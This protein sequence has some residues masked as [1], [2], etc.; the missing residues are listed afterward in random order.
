MW[1]STPNTGWHASALLI[2]W[3][4]R[5]PASGYS[6]YFS[7]FIV[8]SLFHFH[9]FQ[10]FISGSLVVL[11][12]QGTNNNSISNP[13]HNFSILLNVLPI[14]LNSTNMSLVDEEISYPRRIAEEEDELKLCKSIGQTQHFLL[15]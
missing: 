7:A 12:H 13:S 1:V 14:C 4:C 5:N 3:F 9:L 2:R 15:S 8:L 10:P 11:V 6:V